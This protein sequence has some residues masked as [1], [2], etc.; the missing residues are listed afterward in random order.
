MLQGNVYLLALTLLATSERG[1][2]PAWVTAGV[3][4]SSVVLGALV[5]GFASYGAN[6]ALENRRRKARAAVRRKAKVYTPLRAELRGLREALEKDEHLQW[7][8]GRTEPD[9]R[10]FDQGPRFYR[11]DQLVADGRATTS[12]SQAVRVRIEAVGA[13]ID[14]FN[15]SLE[16]ATE[17]F[18]TV[19]RPL[20]TDVMGKELSLV[21]WPH[22]G[23]RAEVIRDTG[24]VWGL[25][26]VGNAEREQNKSAAA[27]FRERFTA[28]PEV[29]QARE[30]VASTDRTLL[31]SIEAAVSELEAAME[32]I[33]E[34]YEKEELED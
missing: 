12:A 21:E 27:E 9:Q 14:G 22:V 24:D 28:I 26:G 8:I 11:W 30:S 3:A 15:R 6:V 29:Q 10:G 20:Y 1:G 4:A 19:G 16:K 5:G 2:D 32:R 25:F 33:A 23:D 18:S 13:A 31:F 7:K 17:V 34:R